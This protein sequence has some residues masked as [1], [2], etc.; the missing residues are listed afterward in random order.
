MD[1]QPKHGVLTDVPMLDEVI[2]PERDKLR[3][4]LGP[5]GDIILDIAEQ[6]TFPLLDSDALGQQFVPEEEIILDSLAYP[7]REIAARLPESLFP[8][9]SMDDLVE[10]I[11]QGEV[12]EVRPEFLWSLLDGVRELG[13]RFRG[14]ESCQGRGAEDFPMTFGGPEDPPMPEGSPPRWWNKGSACREGAERLGPLG[15]IILDLADHIHFPVSNVS[16]LAENFSNEDVLHLGVYQCRLKRIFLRVPDLI[17][18]LESQEDLIEKLISLD[19]GLLTV[20][21][22]HELLREELTFAGTSP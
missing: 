13:V 22:L 12:R 10:K 20:E 5:L 3:R 17:F 9:T 14:S 6:L 21:R 11:E 8:L 2:R 15:E 7:L 19:F 18:P 16:E 1:S 4:L